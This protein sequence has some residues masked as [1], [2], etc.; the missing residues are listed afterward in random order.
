VRISQA[1]PGKYLRAVDI[2]DGMVVTITTVQPERMGRDGD[3]KPVVYF[4]E[5]QRGLVLN[6]TNAFR[7]AESLGDDTA[8]WHGRRIRLATEWYQ[9]RGQSTQGIVAYV[10]GAFMEERRPPTAQESARAAQAPLDRGDDPLDDEIPFVWAGA[11]L[12]PWALALL[13]AGGTA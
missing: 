3:E 8:G 13:G 5:D 10:D 9:V 6:Q 2:G 11:V 4:R 1:F 7:L 12:L